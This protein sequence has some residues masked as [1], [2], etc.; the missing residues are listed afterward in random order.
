MVHKIVNLSGR[1]NIYQWYMYL[2]SRQLSLFQIENWVCSHFLLHFVFG[3]QDRVHFTANLLNF[4]KSF[5]NVS[6]MISKLQDLIWNLLIQCISSD[7]KIFW[8]FW[9]AKE[10]L[11]CFIS[12]GYH[13][14]LVVFIWMCFEHVFEE[15][16]KTLAFEI[17]Y[18]LCGGCKKKNIIVQ[19][20]HSSMTGAVS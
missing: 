7:A 9:I 10:Y 5:C 3:E 11:L 13:I 4:L 6:F 20:F 16:K 8:K 14:K 19:Y 17:R 1:I 12:P 18:F 15:R 2:A